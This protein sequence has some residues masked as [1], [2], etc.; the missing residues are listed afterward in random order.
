MSFLIESS[1]VISIELINDN[2]LRYLNPI[3]ENTINVKGCSAYWTLK[4]S[5]SKTDAFKHYCFNLYQLLKEEN[6]FMC[7]DL[8]IPTDVEQICNS[9]N[10][11][12]NFYMYMAEGKGG[13]YSEI[14]NR[15]LHTKLILFEGEE[16]DY[17]LLG[18]HN[19]TSQALK[20]INKEA[21]VL[22]QVKA[23]SP[24]KRNVTNYLEYIKSICKKLPVGNLEKWML[25]LVQKKGK[26]DGIKNMNFIECIVSNENSFQSIKEGTL[27]HLISFLSPKDEKDLSKINDEFCL[28]IQT[29]EGMR[30]FFVVSV[31]KSSKVDSAI[32]KQSSGQSFEN[33]LYFYIGFTKDHSRATPTVIFPKRNLNL[34]ISF[35]KENKYNLELKVKK[36][37]GAIKKNT[38]VTTSIDVWDNQKKNSAVLNRL[39]NQFDDSSSEIERDEFYKSIRIIDVDLLDKIFDSKNRKSF[40]QEQEQL[41]IGRLEGDIP[42]YNVCDNYLSIFKKMDTFILSD[43][44]K[45]KGVNNDM[46]QMEFE[47]L[48]A[49]FE[50]NG[51]KITSFEKDTQRKLNKNHSLVN[52]G[53][54]LI[55]DS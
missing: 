21:S 33:R 36:E 1:D 46:I 48:Y 45:R 24:T 49:E 55:G 25:E 44:Q 17:I 27:I 22:I 5:S 53:V 16:F 4:H 13:I 12:G 39:I 54:A 52:N 47:K 32:K 51:G 20:N 37:I 31:D 41:A 2:F 18:S 40:Y 26:L 14:N 9:V 3:L 38:N 30:K 50:K 6:S 29:K 8:H 35:L 11:G 7:V 34:S 19:Q 23:E 10:D 43:T 42:I 28:S 15:L